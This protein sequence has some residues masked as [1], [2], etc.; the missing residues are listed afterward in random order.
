MT[1]DE[2]FRQLQILKLDGYG[3]ADVMLSDRTNEPVVPQR[4]RSVK[5]LNSKRRIFLESVSVD[6]IIREANDSLMKQKEANGSI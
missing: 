4:L 5:K 3:E 6:D 2:L 1:V